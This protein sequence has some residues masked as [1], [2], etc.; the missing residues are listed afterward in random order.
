MWTDSV[1]GS[2]S[3]L[4][5]GFVPG[6]TIEISVLGN[7]GAEIWSVTS[8][9]EEL[10]SNLAATEGDSTHDEAG[11]INGTNSNYRNDRGANDLALGDAANGAGARSP[12]AQAVQASES[13]HED[14]P[15][16]P[17][18]E[19]GTDDESDGEIVGSNQRNHPLLQDELAEV[20]VVK[21]GTSHFPAVM[22][23]ITYVHVPASKAAL[24]QQLKVT[25]RA[26][27]KI[28]YYFSCASK[29]QYYQLVPSKHITPI[30]DIYTIK[31][32]RCIPDLIH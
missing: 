29:P 21:C 1:S 26:Q 19:S 22:T 9:Y 15:D 4:D 14:E 10:D 28:V 3:I 7:G 24:S 30:A 5:F 8:S 18:D 31:A 23:S 13:D 32:L 12:F 2:M 17:L 11:R 6:C 20:V 27:Q 16:T 25:N